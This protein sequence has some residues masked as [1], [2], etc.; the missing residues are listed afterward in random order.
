[1]LHTYMKMVGL[2]V[3]VDTGPIAVVSDN[4]PASFL[5]HCIQAI[6]KQIGHCRPIC[7]TLEGPFVIPP[8]INLHLHD[9]WNYNTFLIGKNLEVA[10]GETQLMM[11]LY[12]RI[13]VV[14]AVHRAVVI[15]SSIVGPITYPSIVMQ[16]QLIKC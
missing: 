14:E 7:H 10:N 4:R 1:M 13:L 12:Q 5:L 9:A 6:R 16:R 8:G 3:N 11:K 2:L 15:I